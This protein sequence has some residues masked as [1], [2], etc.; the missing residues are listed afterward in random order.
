MKTQTLIF[1]AATLLGL[2]AATTNMTY[3]QMQVPVETKTTITSTGT[4]TE[5]GPDAIAVKVNTSPAPVRYTFTKTTTYVDENGNPVSVETV[6]TGAPVTVYYEKNGDE[7]IADKVVLKKTISTTTDDAVPAGASPAAA[8]PSTDGVILGTGW[9]EIAVR[10]PASDERVHYETGDSTAYVDENGNPVSRSTL[11]EGT[12]VT[13]FYERDG[14]S[15]RA[16]RI[17]VK[18]PVQVEKTTTTTEQTTVP[19]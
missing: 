11:K 17:V 6:K 15:L 5:L 1:G 8:P 9:G 13:I 16:T 12:P 4:L 10:T 18:S 7:L 14:D 3:G 19:Q 2:L